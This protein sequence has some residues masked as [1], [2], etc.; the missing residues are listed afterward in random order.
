MSAHFEVLR[1]GALTT[2]QDL[3]RTGLAHLAVP[4]SGA[5]DE[6]ALRLANR[7]VGNP[8]GYAGLETTVDGVALRV[9]HD[10]TIALTGA[11]APLRIG[12]RPADFGLPQ[13]VLAGQAVELGRAERGVRSYLALAG[14][15]RTAPVLGSRST[16]LL[17]GLG[18]APLQTGDVL[19][20]GPPVGAPA[21]LD[22]APYPAPP[23][24]LWLTCRL[25]P[26]ADW[27]TAGALAALTAAEWQ[28]GEHS[29][30]IGLRLQGEPLTR[31]RLGELPSEGLT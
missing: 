28:V 5:L 7:L 14:G 15:V 10:L 18:P 1:G 20:V 2:V 16:D 24:E 3:G 12:G 9:S 4:R 19:P 25:G 26:R 23:A 31:R 13:R 27:F 8:E 11:P 21:T 29:N 30:R 17:S 6:P 22:Y